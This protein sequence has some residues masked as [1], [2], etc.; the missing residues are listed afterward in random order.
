MTRRPD[1]PG[2]AHVLAAVELVARTLE[3]RKL[4]PVQ[5]SQRAGRLSWTCAKT[6]AHIAD[7]LLYYAANLTRRSTASAETP[8][9]PAD[10]KPSF[11]IDSMRSAGALLATAVRDAA[12]SDRGWHRYGIADRSG[13]AAM[14]CDEVLVHGYDIA[15]GLK[16]EYSP[17]GALAH[18]TVRRLFPWAP[19]PDEA[20]PWD[21][22]LWANGRRK[23][24][25][26]PPE[27]KWLWHCA[28]L[29]EWNGE[30]RR[31]WPRG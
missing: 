15:Q 20:D 14:G 9:L 29:D 11:V 2:P 8:Y 30:I 7:A 17:P 28:P 10:A 21:A 5:L 12:P 13:F 26:R 6:L 18:V 22:L 1:Q 27:T 31:W 19:G 4:T 24:G 16:L 3:S 25:D 23:L